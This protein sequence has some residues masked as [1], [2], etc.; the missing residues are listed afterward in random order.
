MKKLNLINAVRLLLIAIKHHI[1][2]GDDAHAVADDEHAGFISPEMYA[3]IR[4]GNGTRQ[5]LPVGTDVLTLGAGR[6]WGYQLKNIVNGSSGVFLID[7]DYLGDSSKKVIDVVQSATGQKY[8]YSQHNGGQESIPK[9]WRESKQSFVL[10]SGN[11]SAINQTL[12]FADLYTKYRYLKVYVTVPDG[13]KECRM[14][15]MSSVSYN[16]T[17]LWNNDDAPAESHYE[18]TLEGNASKDGYIIRINHRFDMATNG[19]LKS[20]NNGLLQVTQIEGVV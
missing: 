15:D 17:N 19:S 6:Y 9:G 10:W 11:A 14:F 1:G 7:V 3:Q 12:T 5:L 2:T 4:S 13:A 16:V 8:S 20:V 18:L